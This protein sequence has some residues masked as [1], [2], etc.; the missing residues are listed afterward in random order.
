MH[1]LPFPTVQEALFDEVIER[2]VSAMQKVIQLGRT[3][4]ERCNISLKT[5]LLSLVVIADTQLISDVQTLRSYVKEELNIR[6]IVLTSDEEQY[7]I[8]LGAR[9]DWPTLG[10]KLK[11]NVQV[12]RKALP[13]LTQEQLKRYLHDKKM[14]VDGIELEENDLT[15]VRVLGK[16]EVRDPKLD[17]PHWEAAFSED[18]II[19]LDTASYP[20][21]LG[22]GI[23]RDIIN[24]IQRMRKKAGL[25]PTDDIQ[26]Q[27]A[28][29]TNPDD[30]DI[31]GVLSSNQALF[32]SSLHGTLE[33]VSDDVSEDSLI[34]EE[35]QDI[36]NLTLMLRLA[37]M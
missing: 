25:V 6:E 27:Y 17:G 36:S 18:S 29:L 21:L 31:N 13:N 28:I 15:V 4:R 37:K 34:L 3:A 8:L 11:K 16:D 35:E 2:K 19:L 9:V 10:K 20:A 14:T 12:V 22:E 23:V 30:V 1:F 33:K 26:M 24:R 32:T 5:P 7:N